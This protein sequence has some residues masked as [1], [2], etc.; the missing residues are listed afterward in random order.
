M[1]WDSHNRY[2]FQLSELTYF[3][4]GVWGLGGLL[5]LLASLRT[6]IGDTLK[7]IHVGL[8]TQISVGIKILCK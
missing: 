8:Y 1:V 7:K 5:V 4:F 6:I 2:T 3:Q